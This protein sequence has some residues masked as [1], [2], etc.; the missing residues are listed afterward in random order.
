MNG[1]VQS[2]LRS[3]RKVV[4]LYMFRPSRELLDLTAMEMDA[5]LIHFFENVCG[6]REDGGAV[7]YEF[8]GD[9]GGSRKLKVNMAEKLLQGR[10]IKGF[11]SPYAESENLFI[12]AESEGRV[13]ITAPSQSRKGW[14][15]A[16]EENIAG[17]QRMDEVLNSM[18]GLKQQ[19]EVWFELYDSAKQFA[20]NEVDDLICLPHIRELEAFDYQVR[21]VKTVIGRMKGRALLCDEVGLGKTV[22][23][24]ISMMEY[25]M[26]GLARKILILV[27]PSLINQW[28]EEMK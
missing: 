20:V 27:P 16:I 28:H 14:H 22:E 12:E 4:N 9:G 21:T 15:D 8:V 25:I 1:K 19:E 3:V 26:R 23:A 18:R 13:R 24:G 5:E 2:D 11:F 17:K 6:L 10:G 7:E